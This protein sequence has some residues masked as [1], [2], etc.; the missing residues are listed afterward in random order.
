MEMSSV[1]GGGMMKDPS[2]KFQ[3][4][5]ASPDYQVITPNKIMTQIRSKKEGQF[6]LTTSTND[7]GKVS[8]N[9]H[10]S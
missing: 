6:L 8:R 9:Q 10:L 4:L 2:I 3:K 5:M 7:S 1:L